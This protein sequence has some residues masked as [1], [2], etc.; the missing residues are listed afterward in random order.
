MIHGP[1]S[2]F[3]Q[4]SRIA[5]LACAL[6]LAILTAGT[7]CSC[8]HEPEKATPPTET[9]SQTSTENAGSESDAN[10]DKTEQAQN[11][12][13]GKQTDKDTSDQA[14]NAAK[15]TFK[16][17]IRNGGG[18][19]GL[20]GAAQD[21]IV[22]AG[23]DASTHEFNLETY[24]KSLSPTTIVYV[25]ASAE[26]ASDIKAEADKI[27]AALG[28]GSVAEYDGDTAGESMDAYDIF[29]I[30]GQDAIGQIA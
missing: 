12:A 3:R 16:I 29:V 20:A 24:E 8:G 25:K 1:N 30:V 10:A 28:F 6:M 14:T 22:A 23:L 19:D 7:L 9:T 15:T 5:A 17:A 27:V 4:A 11:E 2:L 21:K 26:H 13:E 18:A